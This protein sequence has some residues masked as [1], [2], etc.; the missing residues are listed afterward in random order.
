[1]SASDNINPSNTGDVVGQFAQADAAATEQAIDAAVASTPGPRP[2]PA[3]RH[4]AAASAEIMA[5]KDE[6]GSAVREEGK[7]LAEELARRSAPPKCSVFR[8]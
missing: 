5:R 1:M 7:T 4:L 6:L 2:D 3:P 8:R